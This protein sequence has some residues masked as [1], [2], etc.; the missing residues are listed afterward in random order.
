MTASAG[1]D[2][3]V[4]AWVQ[5]MGGKTQAT[6]VRTRAGAVLGVRL[7][8]RVTPAA[9]ARA[10]RAEPPGRARARRTRGRRGWRG[11]PWDHAVVSPQVLHAALG[12]RPAGQAVGVAR[13][14]PR[15]GP[16]AVWRAGRVVAGRTRPLGWAGIP[17]PW[18]TGRGRATTLALRQ[19]VPAA[20]PA[21]GRGTRVAARGVPRAVLVAPRRRGQTDCSGR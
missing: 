11:P 19:R 14:T 16:W 5:G 1:G 8:P 4:Q 3:R 10:L 18:P 12:L 2:E 17:S 7:A 20:C 15:L 9:L 13:A 21:G 6:G